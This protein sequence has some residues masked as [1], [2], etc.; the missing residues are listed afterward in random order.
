MKSLILAF[1]L[2]AS[3]SS[4]AVNHVPVPDGSYA[5]SGTWTDNFGNSGTWTMTDVVS[6]GGGHHVFQADFSDGRQYSGDVD[7][8]FGANS[9]YTFV[10]MVGGNPVTI[11]SGVSSPASY[12]NSDLMLS[13]TET[14][15]EG[16]TYLGSHA[17]NRQGTITNSQSGRVTFL[18]IT[19]QK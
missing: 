12:Q 16:G 2:L 1:A 17:W 8:V 18:T 6:C 15:D 10:A 14:V 4:Y 13:A 9:T 11:G 5:G 3:V 19:L 7:V